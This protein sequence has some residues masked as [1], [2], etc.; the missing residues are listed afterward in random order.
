MDAAPQKS[1]DPVISQHPCG[2]ILA[3]DAN[4]DVAAERRCDYVSS[5]SCR[6]TKTAL[7]HFPVVTVDDL[8]RLNLAGGVSRVDQAELAVLSGGV[9]RVSESD[10][11][12]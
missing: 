2:K 11:E 12:P 5:R 8:T 7:A 1:D 3:G 9:A 6:A 4:R 10:R